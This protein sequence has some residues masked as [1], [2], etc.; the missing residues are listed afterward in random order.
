M[1][2]LDTIL[3]IF[4]R[5]KKGEY[6]IKKKVNILSIKDDNRVDFRFKFAFDF[7]KGEYG[8]K[9]A[10]VSIND[11]KV[12]LD[13]GQSCIFVMMSG[14]ADTIRLKARPDFKS[15]GCKTTWCNDHKIRDE[16]I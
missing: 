3:D 9:K 5:K 1:E 14:D 7:I 6:I 8:K 16:D 15:E 4:K 11:E 2:I 13:E 12:T 10:I